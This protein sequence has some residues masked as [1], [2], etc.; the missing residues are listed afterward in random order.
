MESRRIGRNGEDS[1][2]QDRVDGFSL[3]WVVPIGCVSPSTF[4]Y[5]EEGERGLEK[6]DIQS[7]ER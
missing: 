6:L 5:T 3:P 2:G 7:L 4:L 1:Q